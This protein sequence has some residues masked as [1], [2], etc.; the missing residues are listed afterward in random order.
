MPKAYACLRF[1]AV[2]ILK[3]PDAVEEKIYREL[4]EKPPP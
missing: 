4:T 3:Y 2:D 1:S